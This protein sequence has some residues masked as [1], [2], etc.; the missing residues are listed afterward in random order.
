M[1]CAI[2][3]R[4]SADERPDTRLG[5]LERQ[6]E[7]CAAYIASQQD[8]GWEELPAR[9][10]DEGWSGGNLRRP[11]LSRL[12]AAAEAGEIDAIV[13]YKID[14]L[15]RSL[16]DFLN[17]VEQ[18]EKVGVR[19]IAITQQ[20]DTTTSAGRLMINVLLSFAQFERE[21]TSDRL[22]DWFAGARARGMYQ[23]AS[24]YGY[25]NVR[26]QLTVVPDEA[27]VVR[28]IH[29]RYAAT[30]S[31]PKV[32]RELRTRGVETNGKLFF[33]SLLYRILRSRVY[34]G[35][36]A[37]GDGWLKGNHPAIITER[38]WA[39]TQALLDRRLWGAA[40]RRDRTPDAPLRGLVFDG[41]GDP[42]RFEFTFSRGKLYRWHSPGEVKGVPGR[43]PGLRFR[44]GD[45]EQAVAAA[46]RQVGYGPPAGGDPEMISV[47]IR[48]AVTRIDV[49]A[50]N[51]TVTLATGMTIDVPHD[52]MC[53]PARTRLF[54]T[55]IRDRQ[56]VNLYSTGISMEETGARL[57]FSR[58][59]VVEALQRLRVP[60]RDGKPRVAA[61]SA[62]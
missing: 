21:M 52:A 6:R 2:Y 9:F 19:L 37:D 18:F 16:R 17:L 29:R 50:H 56:L 33:H 20:L 43:K 7:L 47:T 10:D 1:R 51:L 24:P 54:A 28:H 45:L 39:R 14:R 60:R 49:R 23:G 3:T 42:M 46:M 61:S 11:A 58:T 26:M 40:A 48:R 15:S 55:A 57:G 44:A 13:L 5:S 59:A 53:V 41:D 31:G 4:K 25:R 34:L 27:E 8:E 22:K 62:R 36:I 38:T 32:L 35:E 12:R 30:R